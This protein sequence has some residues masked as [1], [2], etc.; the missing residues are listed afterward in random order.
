MPGFGKPENLALLQGNLKWLQRQGMDV[1]CLVYVYKTEDQLPLPDGALAPCRVAREGGYWTE[2]LRRA[3]EALWSDV[4][5][6][7]VWLDDVEVQ[8][9]L[10]LRRVAEVMDC[11]GLGAVSLT[12]PPGL[13]A[14]DGR[15]RVPVMYSDARFSVGR[16]VDFMEYNFNLLTPEKFRCLRGVLD[17]ENVMGWGVAEW[18]AHDCGG[19]R[20]AA[21]GCLAALDEALMRDTS[22]GSYNLSEAEQQQEAYF[23]ARGRPP[24]A[25]PG[26]STLGALLEPRAACGGREPA[27]PRLSGGGGATV[28]RA[29]PPVPSEAADVSVM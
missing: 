2:F 10:S 7:L 27:P 22:T 18:F 28:A 9:G 17:P 13:R 20:G 21:V 4:D 14:P 8:P 26:G 1:E 23:A 19:A 5:Y 3:P 11:N 15:G 16:R 12:Y 25:V 6:V 24:M 29:A